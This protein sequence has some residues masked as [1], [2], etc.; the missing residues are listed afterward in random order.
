MAFGV[1]TNERPGTR[2]QLRYARFSAYKAR[3]VLNLIRGKSVAE[4]RA[5]LQF[6]ERGASEPILKLLESAV[7]NAE[8]N[9]GISGDE[10]F[11]SACFADEGPTLKRFRPRARGRAGKIR[12]R[13]CHLTIIVSRYSNADLEIVRARAARRGTVSTPAASRAARVARSRRSG[14]GTAAATDTE[15]DETPVDETPADEA[16]D[17]ATDEVVSETA[18]VDAV[19]ND[20]A[21]AEAAGDETIEADEAPDETTD[22]TD[23]AT[24][25]E[26]DN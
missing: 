25:A 7:A 8:N 23:A 1:K 24:E 6:V 2:A 11:V 14:A 9:D 13:T 3:E 15:V 18:T 26:G 22:S 21:E 19:E 17:A 16:D 10:L 12:K 20:A 5:I 4:A